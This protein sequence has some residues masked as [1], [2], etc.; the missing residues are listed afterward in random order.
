MSFFEYADHHSIDAVVLAAV[1]CIGFIAPF[2]YGFRAYNRYLRSKN[3]AA[4]GWPV[5]PLDA[6][7]DV[8]Y[9]SKDDE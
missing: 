4:H 1:A 3:I 6:D 5:P 2:R 7:G 8:I 9:P